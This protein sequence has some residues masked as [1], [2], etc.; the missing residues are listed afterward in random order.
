[1][2]CDRPSVRPVRPVPRLAACHCFHR[3]ALCLFFF[4]WKGKIG[5]RSKGLVFFPFSKRKLH[6]PCVHV[7]HHSYGPR[8]GD[9]S[10][11][12]GRLTAADGKRRC[13]YISN[14]T[15]SAPKQALRLCFLWRTLSRKTAERWRNDWNAKHKNW[16]QNAM[17][18]RQV[19][20]HA[21]HYDSRPRWRNAQVPHYFVV[22]TSCLCKNKLWHM[23]FEK[24]NTNRG[25][26][27]LIF[28]KTGL[29]I[30]IFDLV[31][32]GSEWEN[33]DLLAFTSGS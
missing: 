8:N 27:C 18:P 17:P 11:E 5:S 16:P 21:L 33:G 6:T 29:N 28:Q 23:H 24:W 20:R 19:P 9:I 3:R 10:W 12:E 13:L 31:T 22:K 32:Y 2:L 14:G 7:D 4:F 26:P 30:A 25:S 15:R 1:M